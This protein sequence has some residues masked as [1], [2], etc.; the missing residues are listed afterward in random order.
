M[1][2]EHMIT[3]KKMESDSEKKGKAYVHWKS[4]QEA[5]QGIVD[6]DYLDN[7][8]LSQCEEWAFKW[9]ENTYVALDG[10]RVVGFVCFFGNLENEEE[11]E[12]NSI[13][14]LSDYYGK[15]VA[16]KL[17]DLALA[18]LKD[19]PVKVL[20]VLKD[21]VRAISFYKKYGFSEDGTKDYLEGLKAFQIK[22][23]RR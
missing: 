4:W 16:Q 20:W 11:A 9:P 2:K 21:N 6:G 14:V 18:E 13:Y 23:V 7:L 17:M 22:M 5:Y 1:G 19:Y 15:G 8:T 3:I 12:I 10:D